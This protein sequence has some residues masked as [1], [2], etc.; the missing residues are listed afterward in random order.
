MKIWATARCGILLLTCAG[1]LL[2]NGCDTDRKVDADVDRFF[3]DNPFVSDPRTGTRM[4][5]QVTPVTASISRVGQPLVFEVSGGS[6]PHTFAIAN[7]ANGTITQNSTRQATYTATKVAPNSIIVYDH[8]GHA[9]I[10][11]ITVESG[12]LPGTLRITADPAANLADD[13]G[14]TVLTAQGGTPPYAWEVGDPLLG[15]LSTANGPSTVYTR[16]QQGDNAVML[17]DDNGQAAHIIV[18][19]PGL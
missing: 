1:T 9:A 11:R 12:A 10:A 5:I 18:R 8:Y 14:K 2:I 15:T 7:N 13:G 17:R 4:Q 6:R 19:Q 3:A 16:L